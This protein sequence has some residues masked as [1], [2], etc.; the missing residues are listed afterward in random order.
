VQ[1]I[2]CYETN[3]H[4]A[5]ILAADCEKAQFYRCD[6]RFAQFCQ[7]DLSE[8]DLREC[9][10]MNCDFTGANLSGANLEMSSIVQCNFDRAA[11][12]GC[13]VF[14]TGVWDSSFAN[15]E[16][17]NLEVRAYNLYSPDAAMMKY[18]VG[19]S[20]PPSF[21]VDDIELAQFLYLLYNN[22]KIRKI[23]DTVSSKAVLLIG[24]FA[25]E[26]HNGLLRLK[27][28]LR[29]LGFVPIVFDTDKPRN[30]DTLE[31]VSTLAH[32]VGCVIADLSGARSVLQELQRIVP[33]L[34]SVPVKPIII[35]SDA[36]PGM[37]D[38]FR[39]YRNCLKLFSYED[40]EHLLAA[41][42]PEILSDVNQFL[43]AK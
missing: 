10:M 21:I 33:S 22:S 8:V 24:R 32:L 12:V 1:S 36:E 7:S 3:F 28:K 9:I 4:E 23:I 37:L 38:H 17:A 35:K 18:L 15:A 34:P 5:D 11:L 2:K 39:Q 16:Q 20:E 25:L 40:V 14:G 42:E 13:R 27:D 6:V 31:T 30:R 29:S 43:A 26:Q 19:Q 41:A